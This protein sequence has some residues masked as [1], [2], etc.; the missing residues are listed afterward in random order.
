MCNYV[1]SVLLLLLLTGQ[2][3]YYRNGVLLGCVQG[4]LPRLQLLLI[5]HATFFVL[6]LQASSMPALDINKR[7]HVGL[8]YNEAETMKKHHTLDLVLGSR[9]KAEFVLRVE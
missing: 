7:V 1:V 5:S 6:H 3:A 9:Q 8:A 2:H 4:W